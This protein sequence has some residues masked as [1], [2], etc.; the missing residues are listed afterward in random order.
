MFNLEP[1]WRAFEDDMD[2]QLA[3]EEYIDG[4][5]RKEKDAKRAQRKESIAKF[6]QLLDSVPSA[7]CRR[8]HASLPPISRHWSAGCSCVTLSTAK[9]DHAH[10]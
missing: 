9:A 5:R 8:R 4:L 10:H 2:R 6:A 3:F 7:M 1:E